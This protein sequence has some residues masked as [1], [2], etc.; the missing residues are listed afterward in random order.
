[1]TVD[2]RCVMC[3]AAFVAVRHEN[4][5]VSSTC[6]RGCRSA[7]AWQTRGV[8]SRIAKQCGRCGRAFT[9]PFKERR[10]LLCSEACRIASLRRGRPRLGHHRP[11]IQCRAAVWVIPATQGRRRFCSL[12]CAAI[13]RVRTGAIKSPTSIE[14]RTYEALEIAAISF[15]PQAA[16]GRYVADAWLPSHRTILEVDGDY[17]H[18]RPERIE[19]DAKLADFCRKRGYGLL[20]LS[21]SLVRGCTANALATHILSSLEVPRADLE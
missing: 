11:C 7:K 19:R 12:S 15:T 17:W 9:V 21:E 4:G 18:S 6:S 8:H 1:M 13:Y 14:R 2:R 20:R 10:A 5:Y 16:F 3:D